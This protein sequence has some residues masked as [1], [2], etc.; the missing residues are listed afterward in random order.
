MTHI[1]SVQSQNTAYEWDTI[2]PE[3]AHNILVAFTVALGE[4]FNQEGLYL[5]QIRHIP[6]TSY[7]VV[8]YRDSTSPEITTPLWQ[9]WDIETGEIV[10]EQEQDVYDSVFSTDGDYFAI[11]I[12]G[13]IDQSDMI[14]LWSTMDIQ[15]RMCWESF[16]TSN[17]S[18]SPSHNW[19]LFNQKID[20]SENTPIDLVVWD[21]QQEREAFR[22]TNAIG[23]KFNPVNS[24]QIMTYGQDIILWDISGTPDEV[25]R[26]QLNPQTISHVIYSEV[27]FSSSGDYLYFMTLSL[28]DGRQEFNILD[29][30]DDDIV[31]INREDTRPSFFRRPFANIFAFETDDRLIIDLIAM[32]ST[33]IIRTIP[34]DSLLDANLNQDLLLMTSGDLRVDSYTF[35]VQNLR[36]AEIY[37][38]LPYMVNGMRY[39]DVRF[40]QD[41]RFIIAY[42]EDGLVQLWGVPAVG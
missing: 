1:I 41:E 8:I 9:I 18:F 38:T 34:I 15:M 27:V 5:Y 35:T 28:N 16:Y 24:E 39:Q 42:T 22:I 7:I 4:P 14:C 23:W 12:E 30:A 2:H 40:T 31:R 21:F 37:A 17:L 10:F 26:Y 20:N 3:N 33:E 19:F 36:T 13:G 32:P 6:N 25:Y 29:I 11:A